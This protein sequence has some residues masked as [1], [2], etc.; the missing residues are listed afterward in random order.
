MARC[1][2]WPS[3]DGKEA[4]IWIYGFSK[5]SAARRLT[6]GGPQFVAGGVGRRA[7]AVT[8]ESTREGDA[9]IWWQ[10]A[11]GTDT[12]TRLTRPEQG[13][14][15]KP[16]SWSPDGKHL[17]FD[18]I[19]PEHVSIWICRSR[20]E[21]DRRSRR[22]SQMPRATPFSPDGK[23]V[24]YSVRPVLGTSQSV[25]LRRAVSA[26]GCALPDLKAEEDGHHPMWSPTAASSSTPLAGQSIPRGARLG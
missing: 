25:A 1:W 19:R 24:A 5:S 26:Y 7:G 3:D 4:A 15:H 18:E 8:F 21:G 22:W 20:T 11:D 6:F 13:A 10:R 17:L 14:S 9:G 16:Q 12:A 2:R 23:W